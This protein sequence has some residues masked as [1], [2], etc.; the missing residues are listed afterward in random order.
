MQTP[1]PIS[2]PVRKTR[3]LPRSWQLQENSWG[4]RFWTISLSATAVISVLLMKGWWVSVG[5]CRS[6]K[7]CHKEKPEVMDQAQDVTSEIEGDGSWWKSPKRLYGLCWCCW[8][9]LF[10]AAVTRSGVS[11]RI[12]KERGKWFRMRPRKHSRPLNNRY[13]TGKSSLNLNKA[14]YFLEYWLF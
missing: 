12:L 8:S 13:L 11:A 14:L 10:F 2:R 7:H 3:S 5:R 1:A 9:A 4:S 6:N